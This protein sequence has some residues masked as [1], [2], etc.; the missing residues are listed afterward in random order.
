MHAE[1]LSAWQHEH[2]FDTGNAAG[3]RSTK[4]VMWMTALM[5]VE[6]PRVGTTTRWRYSPTGFT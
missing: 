6:S 4:I 2:V 1:N 3:E 5:M